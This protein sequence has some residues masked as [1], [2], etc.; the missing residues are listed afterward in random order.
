MDTQDL[1]KATQST[2][3]LIQDDTYYKYIFKKT[4]RIVSVVFYI[5]QTIQEKDKYQRLIQDIE[6]SARRLH[7]NVLQSLQARAH[8]AEES[9]Q[10]V[11]HALVTFESKLAVAQ[12]ASVLSSE[13]LLVINNEV[14]S[15]LR[16]L[17]KYSNEE[18]MAAQAVPTVSTP[19]PNRTPAVSST[20]PQATAATTANTQSRRARILTIIEAKGEVSIKDITDIITDISEKTIQRELNAMIEDNQIKRIG[21]RRWSKYVLF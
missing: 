13:V 9:V 8:V 1:I 21:E 18:P 12:A 10:N 17:Q 3:R 5:T 6:D 14:D 4:E 15:V 20:Q 2:N 19:K 16:A 11:V 7:D